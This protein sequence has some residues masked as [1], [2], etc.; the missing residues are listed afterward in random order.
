MTLSLGD[1]IGRFEVLGCLGVGGMG[2][3]YRARDPQLQ[4]EVAIKVLP[5]AVSGEPDRQRRFEQEARAAGSLN[6]PNILAVYDVGVHDGAT[7]IVT[8]LLVGET[9]RQRMDGR[10]LP[11]RTVVDYAIQIASG[12]AAAHERGIVHRDIKPA[13]LFVTT[14][15]R[16]KILDFGIA[17]LIGPDESGDATE[18]ITIDGVQRAR[19][20]GT[21]IYMSPEQ[22]RGLRTDHRS[23]IFSF[24][25][26]LYEMVAG[27]PPFRRGTTADTLSAI[28]NDEP[29]GFSS[30]TPVHGGLDRLVRHCLEKEPLAR[31]QSARDLV[32][33]LENLPNTS[34]TTPAAAPRRR[35]WRKTAALVG[36]ALLGVSAV[37][38][39][40]YLAGRRAAPAQNSMTVPSVRRVTDFPG[41]EESPSISPD[42]RSV[43]FTANVNGRRQI[44]VRL[45]TSGPP[46]QITKEPIDHQLP[47]WSPDA[48]SLLYLLAGRA[49][50][51]AGD[52]LEH[53][54]AG[55]FSPS[56][57][58]KH[59]GWRRQ[60]ERAVGVLQPRGRAYSIGLVRARRF[61]RACDRTP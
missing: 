17:K 11:P 15:G 13:N 32:F 44:F 34:G 23:D 49:G 46:L 25:T 60:Q 3:V 29:P 38:L 20:V 51:C 35:V 24:G 10:P 19:V 6:H 57:H 53:S 48:S 8:E 58:G 14:D 33:D 28:V 47:R 9:L 22:A 31:F 45:L 50:R 39:L 36:L 54:R 5:A 42:R 7:W 61:R 59:R 30:T 40:G 1:R 18:T 26:V 16:V 43:A 37:V 55:W 21:A 4:R 56:G 27:L 52:H 41:L 2:E 12:L